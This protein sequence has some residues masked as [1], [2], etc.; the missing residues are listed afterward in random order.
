MGWAASVIY[1]FSSGQP[2]T[3]QFRIIEGHALEVR[4]EAFNLTGAAGATLDP[5]ILQKALKYTF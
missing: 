1:R 5:R 3:R 4:A 2:L